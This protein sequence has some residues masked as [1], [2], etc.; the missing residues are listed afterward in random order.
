MIFFVAIP[1]NTI[2]LCN[3]Y[4]TAGRHMQPQFG[5]PGVFGYMHNRYVICQNSTVAYFGFFSDFYFNFSESC[6]MI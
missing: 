6:A 2:I 5:N 4:I 3:K 1:P